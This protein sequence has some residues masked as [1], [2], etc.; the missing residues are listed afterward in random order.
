M[1][2]RAVFPFAL[3][4]LLTP[5]VALAQHAEHQHGTVD[6]AI[7][8][9]DEAQERFNLGLAQLHHMMYDQAMPH[10][11]AAAEADPDCAMAHWGIAMASFQPLWHPTPDAGLERGRAA[12]ERARQ[13]GAPTE[14]E[15][16]HLAAVDAFF[17]DPSP[18]AADR[19]SDH[20]ARTRAWMDAQREAH[21]AHPDDED[22]AA[23][24]A[25][26]TV[27]HAQTQFAPDAERDYT[28]QRAA[29]AVLERYLDDHPEHPGLH[30]YLIHAYDSPALADEAR[31]V[32]ARYDRLAPETAHA[33]HM[34]SHIFVRLGQWE[35]TADLNERS[36]EA[37]LRQAASD[38]GAIGHYVH[39]LDYVMYAYLQ[40]GDEDRARETLERVRAVE[41]TPAAL[42]W[43]YGIAAPQAR[44]YL[45]RQRWEEAARLEPGQPAILQWEDYPAANA[46][47]HYA[48]G[49]G[50]ARSG[51]LDQAE[52]E[53]ARI[54]DAV[55]SLREAG[56]AYWAHL[57]DA[58]GMAVEAW[59]LYERGDADQA[60]ALM[61]EA[62][63][64]EDSMDKHPVTPGEV[65][66]VRELYGE[67]LLREGR[68][69]DARAAFEASLQ[70]TPN[71]RNGL[72][73]VDRARA[74]R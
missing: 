9:N 30:H 70:R 66:P 60:L 24:Y 42:A 62:A 51:D 10:F 68:A 26:A 43:A 35:E 64:L 4:A 74:G 3:A 44:Y 67:L 53:A 7:S 58:L 22:A 12:L 49:L 65:L 18:P 54:D 5:A 41:E 14:R 36:A 55:R 2:L 29:G 40:M 33:L 6:F 39:A 69:D 25:L 1:T 52:V 15:R 34:P 50:A 38:P 32:A 46:L 47:F 63:D 61:S 17:A 28:A 57:T 31:S 72:A 19:P 45:E 56:D 71:R 11:E 73:G 48:R 8:C 37:A 59:V 16:A 23:F 13:I 20:A 27:A 21:E